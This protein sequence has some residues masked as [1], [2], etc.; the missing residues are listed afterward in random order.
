MGR[1]STGTLATVAGTSVPGVSG[2]LKARK[3][4]G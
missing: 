2:G 3:N 4:G 1:F